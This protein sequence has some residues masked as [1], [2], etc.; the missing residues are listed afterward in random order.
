MTSIEQEQNRA[1]SHLLDALK[2]WNQGYL[3]AESVHGGSSIPESSELRKAAQAY[4][5]ND[6]I[7][8]NMPY[9][10]VAEAI[11]EYVRHV[12]DANWG[13]EE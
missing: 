8:R 6:P 7:L 4:C 3:D 5:L 9:R 13:R 10:Q 12:G 1:I 11:E 2:M